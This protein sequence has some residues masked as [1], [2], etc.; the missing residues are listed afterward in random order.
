MNETMRFN[1]Y[2]SDQ[3]HLP[4]WLEKMNELGKYLCALP[5][6]EKLLLGLAHQILAPGIIQ[7]SERVAAYAEHMGRA[8]GLSGS[9]VLLLT[10]AAMLHDIGKAAIPPSL[11]YKKE[12]L[13]SAE[14]NIIKLHSLIGARLCAHIPSLKPVAGIIQIHHERFDGSGYPAGLS[15]NE[16]PLHARILGMVDCYDALTTERP[17]KRSF[18]EQRALKIMAEETQRGLWDPY[19]FELFTEIV[20]QGVWHGQLRRGDMKIF[21]N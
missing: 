4:M 3:Y 9:D 11:L 7:H 6:A 2:H 5:F 21:K 17:Y 16:I 1:D 13:T 15:G 8:V 18:T 20:S 10:K 19:L 14:Y 12:M